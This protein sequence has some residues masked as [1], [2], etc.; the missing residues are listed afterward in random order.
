MTLT[1]E[2]LEI[3]RTEASDRAVVAEDP[4]ERA[5][6]EWIRDVIARELRGE[7]STLRSI[8]AA[9]SYD[10]GEVTAQLR[11]RLDRIATLAAH[12]IR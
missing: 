4:L 12:P 6:A 8:T 5:G 9:A 2:H 1:R 3:L 11:A 10:P 7:P